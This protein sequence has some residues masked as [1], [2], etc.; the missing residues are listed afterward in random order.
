MVDSTGRILN[1]QPAH[2]KLINAEVHLQ[3]DDNIQ[4]A[5]VVRRTEGP[6][7][8]NIGSY[9]K[10]L[11]VNSVIYDVEFPD[12]T[13]KEYVANMIAEN[14]LSQVDS[15]GYSLQLMDTIVDFLTDETAV[16]KADGMIVKKHGIGR[17]CK[18]TKGWKLLVKWQDG[19]ELW[20]PLKDPKE[21]NPVEV[22]EFAKAQG[23]ANEPTFKWWVWYILRK[24][25]VILA[26][27]KSRFLKTTQ[28]YSIKMPCTVKEDHCIDSENKNT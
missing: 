24:R 15:E 21:S 9:N 17:P 26:L 4:T 7:G 23:I 18:T 19:Q 1:S 14:M 28:K 6:D 11:A 3:Q 8:Q 27:V 16:T 22:A 12:S 20:I 10:N 25:D 13:I 2:D 5:R